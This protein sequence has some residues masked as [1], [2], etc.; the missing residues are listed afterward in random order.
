M[1][2]PSLSAVIH[3]FDPQLRRILC[4]VRGADHRST[5]HLRSVSCPACVALTGPRT[6]NV[7]AAADPAAAHGHEPS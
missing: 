7:R 3:Y 5:K 2:E 4:G 6:V 1:G